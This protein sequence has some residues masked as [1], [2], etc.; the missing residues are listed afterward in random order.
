[1]NEL[2]SRR[3]A[4]EHSGAMRLL[5]V[6]FFALV[7]CIVS[8]SL[9][10]ADVPPEPEQSQNT[11]PPSSGGCSVERASRDGAGASLALGSLALV[12]L[13]RSRR[14]SSSGPERSP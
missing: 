6:P 14:R 4:G 13:G 7:L 3:R 5:Y 10:R 12:L 11:D 1:M 9:A 8:V 2:L